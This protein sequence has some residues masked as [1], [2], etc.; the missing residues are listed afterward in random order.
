MGRDLLQ[1]LQQFPERRKL[2]HREAGDVAARARQ[3]CDQAGADRIGDLCEDD[4]YAAGLLQQRL[5]RQRAA[6]QDHVRIE[7]HELFRLGADAPGVGA[8]PAIVDAGVAAVGPPQL[9]QRLPERREI[10][11]HCWIVLG[12][13]IQ[14]ANPSDA[15]GLLRARREGP[16]CRRAAEQR[17]EL[18]PFHVEHG[19]LPPLRAVSAADWPVRSVF[20]TSSLPQSGREV[21]GADLNCSESR[22]GR[23]AHV[24]PALVNQE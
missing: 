18:A 7:A 19:G 21:L 1:H 10:G 4:R 5:Q 2:G 24:P 8:A 11:L 23:S 14:H 15:V 16:R 22:R 12:E 9:L 3:A 6:D 20:H 17:D 13:R